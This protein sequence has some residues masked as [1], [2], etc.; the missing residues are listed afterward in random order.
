MDRRLYDDMLYSCC[1]DGQ[2]KSI[3]TCPVF[4]RRREV[5]G[6]GKKG[7]KSHKKKLFKGKKHHGKSKAGQ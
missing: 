1:K 5:E 4:R 7:K 6:K 2:I 3:G